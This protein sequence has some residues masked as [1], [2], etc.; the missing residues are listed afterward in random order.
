MIK[1]HVVIKQSA[2][3]QI[4]NQLKFFALI[5]FFFFLRIDFFLAKCNKKH[6]KLEI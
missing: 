5:L 3:S 1:I 2:A 4:F 6:H